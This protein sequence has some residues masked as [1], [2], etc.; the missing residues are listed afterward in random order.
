MIVPDLRGHGRS[1][2][3]SAEFSYRQSAGDMFALL[4]HLGFKRVRGIG[5]GAGG[6]TF[7]RMAAL[8]AHRLEAMILVA[9][10]HRLTP[11]AR[12][13][14]RAMPRFEDLPESWEE[15]NERFH[16]GAERQIRMLLSQLR[17]FADSE[18]DY[19][20]TPEDLSAIPVRTFLVWGDR[21]EWHPMETVVEL[22]EALPNSQLWVVPGQGHQAMW[23]NLGGSELAATM[24]PA[25]ALQFLAADE[26]Q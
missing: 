7:L 15:Y 17:A 13:V 1:T 24:F 14:A 16:P 22:Y 4:D 23:P 5:Y 26:R 3:P 19:S 8:Q 21:D 9:G 18:D 12:E 10:G 11:E 20:L 25:L 2:N 6:C